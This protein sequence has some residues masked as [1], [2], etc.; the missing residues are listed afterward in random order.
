MPVNQQKMKEIVVTLVTV[1]VK[2]ISVWVP[3]A[4]A[5]LIYNN[6]VHIYQS[7]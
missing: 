6:E 1:V 4:P 7:N 5:S 3:A 2:I